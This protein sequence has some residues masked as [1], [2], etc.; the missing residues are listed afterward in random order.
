MKKIFF[1]FLLLILHYTIH[2]QNSTSFDSIAKNKK[3]SP[4]SVRDYCFLLGDDFQKQF[5]APFR[6]N[7]KQSIHFGEF[8]LITAG[9]I[10]EDAKIDKRANKIVSTNSAVKKSSPVITQFGSNYGIYS[11]GVFELYGV[12]FND[13][14]AQVTGLLISQALITSGIWTRVGKLI[15][16]RER[17]SASYTNSHE[18]GGEWHGFFQCMEYIKK[19]KTLPGASYDAF[20][21]GHT[22]TAFSIATVFAKMYD[23]KLAVP[24]IAYSAASLV[25]LSRLTEHAHWMSDVFVGAALGYLCGNQVVNNYRNYITNS[26]IKKRKR[27]ISLSMDYY[28]KSFLTG[29]NYKL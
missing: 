25:G 11:A 8:T 29:I 27:N 26:A 18:P 13:K 15:T 17:P 19:Y 24:I 3:I 4:L 28:N 10:L 14:K 6:I 20:P 21:S 9:L 7:E 2:A 16:G 22:S 12:V 23:D 5:T 1:Y